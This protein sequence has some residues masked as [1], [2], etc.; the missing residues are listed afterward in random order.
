MTLIDSVL[1]LPG[2]IVEKEYKRR[3]ATINTMI[4]VYNAEEGAP[5]RPRVP[6]KRT[7]DTADMPPA[8]PL[9]KRQ[10]SIPSDESSDTF[11]KAIASVYVKSPG[12]RPT[13]YFICLGNTRSSERNRL[14]IY[15]NPRSLSRHFVN[16]HIKPYPND[17][18]C[19]CNIY[20]E[21][22]I[23]K[24]G[25]LNHARRIHGTVSSLPLPA[26]SL[27]LP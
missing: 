15:K 2:T 5:S 20:G 19:D 11:S 6:Q 12:E 7:A 23:S 24:T 25:L 13:I 4:A 3:I 17:I 16:K 27:P 10:T 14:T 8:A 21:R 26:L 18:H 9:P 1:T 22:L